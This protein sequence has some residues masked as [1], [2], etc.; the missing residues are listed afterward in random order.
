MSHSSLAS[1]YDINSI[2]TK[3]SRPVIGLLW[4]TVCL[5]AASAVS[6]N[7]SGAFIALGLGVGLAAIASLAVMK[8]ASSSTASVT[9][10]V[11]LAGL[12]AIIVYNF[13]WNGEGVA[14]QIDLHM[15]FFAGL[16]I[17]VAFLDWKALV[18]FTGVVAFHHLT[19]AF[20]LPSAVF[21]DGAPILRVALHGGI[22]SLECAVLLWMVHQVHVLIAANEESMHE[23]DESHV[24]ASKLQQDI[25][26]SA[27]DNQERYENLQVLAR[28][29]R[30]EVETLMQELTQRANL[31]NT[32]AKGLSENASVSNQRSGNLDDATGRAMDSVER[33]AAATEEFSSSIAS[34]LSQINSTNDVI[35]KAQI[36]VENSVSK[37]ATLA[38]SAQ[39]IGEVVNL[40]QSIAEQTNLLA[41]NATIEAARSGDAGKGFAV[42]AEEVKRLAEQTAR[43][44]VQIADQIESIQSDSTET[45]SAIQ[46]I[47]TVIAQITEHTQEVGVSID[48]QNAA[49]NEIAASTRSAADSTQSLS[50]GVAEARR[51]SED[52]SRVS[53]DIVE[54]S[55]QVHEAGNTLMRSID[56]FLKKAVG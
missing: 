32:S 48:Q 40:I 34:I 20:I 3:F 14:Y 17:M 55:A 11:A 5:I 42:V 26:K 41:L 29:F 56:T 33:V 6:T 44:T 2:R 1:Q 27:A 18:A 35:G 37:V 8:D 30:T 45:S 46:Q 21:P 7:V 47:S 39:N 4:L 51:S 28:S 23:A 15:A 25:E 9:S 54:A 13:S 52:V 43:A 53:V 12:I 16:A 19:L 31:L 24:E 22:L 36:S 38:S 10:G 49:A 50:R